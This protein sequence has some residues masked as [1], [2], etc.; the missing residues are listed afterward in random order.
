MNA[1]VQEAG[2]GHNNPPS[3][4]DEAEAEIGGLYD[5]AKHWLDGSG[6]ATDAD[7]DGVGKLLD[8]LRKAEKRADDL[9]KEE[10]RP[11][12]DAARAVQTKWKPILDR[13]TLAIDACKKALAPYLAKKEAAQRIEAEARRREAEE[14]ETAAR[15]AFATTRPDDLEGREQAE[16]Q[17]ELA[18]DLT[19]QAARVAK[20]KPQ[21]KGGV[22]AIGLRTYYRAEV[23]DPNAFAKYVWANHRDD[24]NAFL[25]ELAQ[26]LVDGKQRDIPGVTVHEDKRA[27]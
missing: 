12:D 25:A 15:E 5:E 13:V 9:R 27:A 19:K 7:A 11:H 16:R 2:L 14:A 8:M 23:S 17:A 3:P 26:R 24:L 18:K 1:K 10:K 22:R 6:V 20:A 21:A 4:F